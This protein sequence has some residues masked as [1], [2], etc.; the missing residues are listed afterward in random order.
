M[1]SAA[2]Y[3]RL[4]AGATLIATWGLVDSP[5]S[6]IL[7]IQALTALSAVRYRFKPYRWLTAAEAALCIGYAFVWLPAL[8]GLW[9]PVISLLEKAWTAWERELSAR[10]IADR[11]ERLKLEAS[12][13][14]T[15]RE[16]RGAARFAELAERSRIAQDI[17][18]HVGHEISGALIALQT[19]MRLYEKRDERAGEL[20]AKSVARVEAASGHLREAI[21]NLKPSQIWDVSA[22]EALC[23]EFTFCPVRFSAGGDL[24]GSPHWELLAQNLKE[25]LTNIAR[26]SGAEFAAVKIDGNAGYIRMQVSDNGTAAKPYKPG[27]GLSG[28][29]ERVRAAGGT[30]SINAEAG[31]TV[32]AVLP[33]S[34]VQ[35]LEKPSL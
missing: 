17:H 9:L 34:A 35:S 29:Q 19:A 15:E 10:Q 24:T 6:G 1:R 8:A 16:A 30:L 11:G 23:G 3:A 25:L 5:L 4:F 32:T 2:I 28:M 12:R 27:L 7:F 21:Y 26:H 13:E 14:L 18:D 22:L 20:L 31:F 33:K